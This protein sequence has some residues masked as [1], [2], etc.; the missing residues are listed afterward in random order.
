MTDF[1]GSDA[2]RGSEHSTTG[3]RPTLRA[4]IVYRSPDNA[5]GRLVH[6]GKLYCTKGLH[7]LRQ[8]Q[9]FF[10]NQE[11]ATALAACSA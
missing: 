11:P 10:W 8:S 6:I 5:T 9:K 7:A 1:I 4:G 3:L 2:I